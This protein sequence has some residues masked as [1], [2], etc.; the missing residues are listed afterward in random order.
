MFLQLIEFRPLDQLRC[1]P[2]G[3]WR[4]S[5]GSAAGCGRQP[6]GVHEELIVR[7]TAGTACGH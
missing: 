1:Q 4:N 5:G 7:L 3:E 2:P 6:A